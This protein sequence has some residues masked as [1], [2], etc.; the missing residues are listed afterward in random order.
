MDLPVKM[1]GLVVEVTALELWVLEHT[2]KEIQA[3]VE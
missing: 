3:V 2:A 1:V